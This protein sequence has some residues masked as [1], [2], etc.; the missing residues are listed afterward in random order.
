MV[1]LSRGNFLEKGLSLDVT[2]DSKLGDRHFWIFYFAS[3]FAP[4]QFC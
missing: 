4:A 3:A 1:I 2:G